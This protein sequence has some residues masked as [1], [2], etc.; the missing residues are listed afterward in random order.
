MWQEKSS[1][2]WSCR[3]TDGQQNALVEALKYFV[4]SRSTYNRLR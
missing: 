3:I 2:K 1:C 4:V